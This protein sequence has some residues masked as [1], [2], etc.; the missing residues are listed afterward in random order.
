MKATDSIRKSR[1]LHDI[2]YCVS[3]GFTKIEKH[4]RLKASKNNKTTK[5]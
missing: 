2:I 4:I 5:N 3:I 1:F